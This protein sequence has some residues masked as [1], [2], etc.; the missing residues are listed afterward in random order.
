MRILPFLPKWWISQFL[1]DIILC[2]TK[3]K[4]IRRNRSEE[5]ELLKK[6]WIGFLSITSEVHLD[7]YF[8]FSVAFFSSLFSLPQLHSRENIKWRNQISYRN[9]TTPRLSGGGGVEVSSA[10]LVEDCCGDREGVSCGYCN[11]WCIRCWWRCVDWVYN[12]KRKK[13]WSLFSIDF[14]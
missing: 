10:S 13:S 2:I 1:F 3:E 12:S 8:F 4:C 7:L 5:N 6:I 14:S 9:P 11:W